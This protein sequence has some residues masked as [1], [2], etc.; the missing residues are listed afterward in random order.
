MN[1]QAL[2][3]LALVLAILILIVQRAEPNR[4]LFVFVIGLLVAE[5]LRRYIVYRDWAREGWWALGIALLANLVFW[6][7]V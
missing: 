4:R 3:G 5:L 2:G 1:W 7:L 6:V